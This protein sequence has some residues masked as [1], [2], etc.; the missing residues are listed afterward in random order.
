MRVVDL[1]VR[2][3]LSSNACRMPILQGAN[4]PTLASQVGVGGFSCGAIEARATIEMGVDCDPE[5][6]RVWASNVPGAKAVL[7]TL[8]PSCTDLDL[9]PP[10]PDL[11]VHL[12]PPCQAFSR[13][14]ANSATQPEVQN[15]LEL[16]RWSIDLVLSRGDFS[17]SLEEVPAPAVR[18][19]LQD[20]AKLHPALVGWAVFDCA[21]FG[22][23][24]NRQRL[25]AGPPAMIRK[26]QESPVERRISVREAFERAEL[27]TPSAF[28]KNN[29]TNRDKTACTRSI[30][31]C[32]FTVCAGH[33]LTWAAD[34]EGNT[35]SVMTARQSALLQGFPLTWTIPSGSSTGQRAVG[36]NVP[37]N[38]PLNLASAIGT[39]TH[40]PTSTHH[41][42]R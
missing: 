3:A 28:F 29:T 7:T 18:L 14:R 17:W 10:A 4:H 32:A 41:L 39:L 8:G 22:C 26:L 6:L 20:Y 37:S 30:E 33:G 36:T 24:Q 23:P 15:S 31:E 40:T 1:F 21:D 12:S 16:L 42:L 11:H 35:V 25:I 5:P 9:P 13:A 2:S 34:R 19:T 27:T 38:L